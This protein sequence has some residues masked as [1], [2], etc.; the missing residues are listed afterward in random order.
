MS[1]PPS[2]GSLGTGLFI[3]TG[4]A[5]IRWG[6]DGINPFGN[7]VLFVVSCTPADE[8]ETNYVENGAGLRSV[9]ILLWQGRRVNITVVDDST[10]TPPTPGQLITYSD[11][12]SGVTFTNQF[13]VIENSYNAARK[14]AGQ[15][16]LVAEFLT[17]IE[18]GGTPPTA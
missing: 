5:T 13:R 3:T 15:R 4:A 12:L 18:G 9:R 1:W 11:P 16:V 10:I 14:E 2:S 7:S 8:I 17:N 6:T